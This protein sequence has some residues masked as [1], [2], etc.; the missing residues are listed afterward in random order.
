MNRR[1]YYGGNVGV[2][3]EDSRFVGG[4]LLVDMSCTSKLNVKEPMIKP[5]AVELLDWNMLSSCRAHY[6]LNTRTQF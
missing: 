4:F 3:K 1:G 6:A 2:W 5:L